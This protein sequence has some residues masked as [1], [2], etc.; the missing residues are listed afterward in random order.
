M[1][2][3]PRATIGTTETFRLFTPIQHKISRGYRVLRSGGPNHVNPH[4]HYVPP[5]LTS[6]TPKTSLTN[7]PQ[8]AALVVMPVEV[9]DNGRAERTVA[10]GRCI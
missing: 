6:E 7:E 4:L 10:R 5:W 3:E 2:A 1:K 9:F 8:R